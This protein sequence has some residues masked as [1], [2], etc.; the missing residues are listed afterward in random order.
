MKKHAA[1][2]AVVLLF[3]L[4]AIL[5][6][7]QITLFSDSHDTFFYM[8][9]DWAFL[10]VQIALV[11]IVVDMIID[12]REKRER[13]SKSRMLASSFF[14]DCGTELLRMLLSCDANSGELVRIFSVKGSWTAEDF[15]SAEEA[16]AKTELDVKCTPDD[17]VKLRDFLLE[18]RLS[19]LVIASNPLLLEH[20]EFTDM[21]WTVFHL[22]DELS[23][24]GDLAA[25]TIEG[26]SHLDLDAQRTLR[27]LIAN[28]L[29]CVSHLKKEYPYLFSLSVRENPLEM[30]RKA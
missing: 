9:Q 29:C 3:I 23:A 7:I 10:P 14:S 5:Y 13:L 25:L 22:S 30:S 6:W 2:A 12:S 1:A 26:A 24:R 18:K 4:S 21:L 27:A 20:E 8:L 11:T 17:L 16:A 19:T 15:A 28:W